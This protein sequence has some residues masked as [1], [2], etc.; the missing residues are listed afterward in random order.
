MEQ[1]KIELNMEKGDINSDREDDY[2]K[3]TKIGKLDKREPKRNYELKA[4]E[5][6]S[7]DAH[8]RALYTQSKVNEA[9]K[10]VIEKVNSKQQQANNNFITNFGKSNELPENMRQF[11][12]NEMKKGGNK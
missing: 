8:D 1:K 5:I 9:M 11:V 3:L 6:M 4:S 7:N 2:K 10:S 12:E